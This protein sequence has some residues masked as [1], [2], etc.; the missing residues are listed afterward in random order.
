MLSILQ[1]ILDTVIIGIL[2]CILKY[3]VPCI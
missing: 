2:K 1:C 3:N